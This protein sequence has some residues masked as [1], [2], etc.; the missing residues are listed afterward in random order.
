MHE[1][2]VVTEVYVLF[3][4]NN[5]VVSNLQVNV[6]FFNKSRLS[7]FVAF[8]TFPNGKIKS[9]RISPSVLTTSESGIT[10]ANFRQEPNKRQ[11]R[12]EGE[13]T[14]GLFS[15]PEYE[16]LRKNVTLTFPEF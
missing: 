9:S 4:K 12:S 11:Q 15:V 1:Q 8:H 2:K 14:M 3:S 6:F 16:N 13:S 5:C 10:S 7:K